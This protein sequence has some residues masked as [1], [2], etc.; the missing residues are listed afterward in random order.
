[1]GSLRFGIKATWF[2]PGHSIETF[3]EQIAAVAE[4]GHEIGVHGYSH[5]NPI[6][7]TPEQEEI[8]LDRCIEL[9]T[10][11]RGKP[12]TGNLSKYFRYRA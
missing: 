6:S 8:V 1:M 10:R 4:A 5:E 9:I 3:P 2:I 12:P 7:M 11:V